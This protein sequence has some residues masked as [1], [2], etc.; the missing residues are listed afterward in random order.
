MGRDAWG[1]KSGREGRVSFYPLQIERHDLDHFK[2]SL[3]VAALFAR[4]QGEG[5][6]D[7][8]PDRRR[9]A[10]SRSSEA[11]QISI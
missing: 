5:G 10:L 2:E 3:R 4:K 7:E 1:E 8:K 11:I 9:L 6:G